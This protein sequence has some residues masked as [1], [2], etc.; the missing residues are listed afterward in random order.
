MLRLGYAVLSAFMLFIAAFSP[1]L[2]NHMSG[3]YV[4]IGNDAGTTLIIVQRSFN[5]QGQVQG[6][7]SG[8]IFATQG[9]ND[10]FSGVINL[11]DGR[12]YQFFAQWQPGQGLVIETDDGVVHTFVFPQLADTVTE[13]EVTQVEPQPP[14]APEEK[15]YARNAG[16][17]L[18]SYPGPYTIAQLIDQIADGEIRRGFEVWSTVDQ[19]WVPIESV[20]ELA[21]ALPPVPPQEEQTAEE[22][23]T[24]QTQ[25]EQVAQYYTR[26]AGEELE[27]YPGPFSVQQVLDQIKAGQVGRGYEIWTSLNQNWVAIE[28]VAELASSLPAAQ[29]PVFYLVF[30]GKS[31]QSGPFTLDQVISGIQ[32]NNVPRGT[33]IWR[34]GWAQWFKIE[35]L[36]DLGPLFP[37]LVPADVQYFVLVGQDRL[38]PLTDAEVIARI[39]DLSSKAEDL[40]WK[41]GL[42]A[43]SPLSTFTEFADALA[44]VAPP[45]PPPD[46]TD[47]G[48]PEPVDPDEPPPVP[49][50]VDPNAPPPT[51]DGVDPN[52]PTTPEGTPEETTGTDATETT[53]DPLL[54]GIEAMVAADATVPEDKR[55]E[56]VSCLAAAFAPLTA[57]D[58]QMV[59]DAGIQ[60]SEEQTATLEAAYPGLSAAVDACGDAARAEETMVETT[61]EEPAPVDEPTTDLPAETTPERAETTPE[62]A[63]T[64]PE[65]AET[66]TEEP[67]ETTTEPV[68]EAPPPV[69]E[70]AEPP[71]EDPFAAAIG[72]YVDASGAPEADKEAMKACVA[73]AT[74]VLTEAEKQVLIDTAFT[75]SDEQ[76][77]AIEAAHPGIVAATE[78]CAPAM[79]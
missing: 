53:T 7:V 51:P 26:K 58:K 71:A 59:L 69:P 49:N 44:A 79:T 34:P 75:P 52:A 25:T 13:P 5:I 54:A 31:G 19:T 32:K 9:G 38:G 10:D 6:S 4:G 63:E 11:S 3:N 23:Q 37:P 47:L 55:A 48:E 46:G 36:T 20:G 61:T 57:E 42:E 8:T 45:P 70:T 62:P 67:A 76:K 22:T 15:Y 16:Q 64:T 14:A 2:A 24:E 40:A 39:R 17:N 66:T 28:N 77:A 21:A 27:K 41:K 18:E 33:L 72:A 78:G 56:A 68:V 50:V 35:D 43:W 12:A 74:A 60:P 73:E 1:A 30:Q 65:P 29:Q